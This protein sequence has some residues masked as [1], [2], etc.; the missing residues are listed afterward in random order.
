MPNVF[1]DSLIPDYIREAYL[2]QKRRKNYPASYFLLVTPQGERKFPVKDPKSG[3]YHYG[4]VRAA[5]T[6]AAQ[7]HYPKVEEKARAILEKYF[8]KKKDVSLEV[9]TK[10]SEGK[11]VFG[12]VLV[13]EK[14]D[15]EGDSYTKEAIEE[16][17]YRFN[18]DFMNQSY[19]HNHLLTKD[20]VSIIESYIAPC[21]MKLGNAVIKEGTWLMRSSVD[22]DELRREVKE[23]V[24]KGFSIGGF[25]VE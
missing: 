17:C 20:Q 21:E 4:L 23:G 5:I 10:D 12:I 24:I 1:K 11:Q 6:R 19:R 7:Y 13:P 9:L 3:E 14:K 22:D 16:A 18:R 15:K 8:K 25:G 2:T